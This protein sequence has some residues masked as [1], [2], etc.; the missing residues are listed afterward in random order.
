[1]ERRLMAAVALNESPA[2]V[3]RSLRG[4]IIAARKAY[5]D[6]LHVEVRDPRGDVWR[7]ATQDAEWSPSDP[8]ELLDLSAES[9]E[10]DEKTGE[11]RLGLSN[12]S[13]LKVVPA[14][15]ESE[16]DPANWKLLTPGGLVLVFGPGG[17][18]HFKRS[19]DQVVA[20]HSHE[21]SPGWATGTEALSDAV[22]F[23]ATRDLAE[24]RQILL[25]E[26][27]HSRNEWMVL[28][29]ALGL[30]VVSIAVAVVSLVLTIH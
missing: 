20:P 14:P 5:P 21:R 15:H 8:S 3:L 23:L 28:T 12:G 10:V 25:D 29:V 4:D 19:D 13:V 22:A 7:L 16:D 9:A 2:S 24:A 11:L 30:S 6:I 1:M 27:A 26:R 17:G 18:W